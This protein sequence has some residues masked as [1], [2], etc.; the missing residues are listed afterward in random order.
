MFLSSKNHHFCTLYSVLCT[1]LCN[2]EIRILQTT[3]LFCQINLFLSSANRGA[4]E[5]LEGGKREKEVDLLPVSVSIIPIMILHSEIN[6]FCSFQF[7]HSPRTPS[8]SPHP[9]QRYQHQLGFLR[10]LLL[11]GPAAPA[12]IDQQSLFRCLFFF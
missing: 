7:F 9:P 10:E 1:L 6:N 4:E 5:A 3:F 11:Q 8:P 12:T 2:D